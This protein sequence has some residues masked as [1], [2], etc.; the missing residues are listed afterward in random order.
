M[1]IT[2]KRKYKYP[3]IIFIIFLIILF[4]GYIGASIYKINKNSE[5]ISVKN[6]ENK[7]EEVKPIENPPEKIVNYKIT[8]DFKIVPTDEKENKKVV[9]LTIDDGPSRQSSDIVKTLS[10]ENIHAIFFIN[11][12]NVKSYPDAIKQEYNAGNMIGNHTWSHKDLKKITDTQAKKEIDDNTEIILKETGVKPIFF[13][14]P[15]GKLSSFAKTHVEKEGML[16]FNWSDAAIDW[17]KKTKDKTVFIKN[18][19]KDLKPGS[20]ILMHEHPW[21]RDALPDLIK[22]IKSKGYTFVDP[23]DIIK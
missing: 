7:V 19:M 11:G 17:D 2:I 12:I 9:L 3:I 20:I 14:S 10:D 15:F 18:V 4:V 23:K 21:S 1:T 16:A 5:Q 13:R 8:K 22:E 6:Q